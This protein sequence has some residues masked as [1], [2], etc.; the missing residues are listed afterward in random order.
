MIADQHDSHKSPED[1]KDLPPP[2][3]KNQNEPDLPPPMMGLGPPGPGKIAIV[4]LW[5]C[6]INCF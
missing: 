5:N 1:K 6:F 4:L 3:Q 2:E